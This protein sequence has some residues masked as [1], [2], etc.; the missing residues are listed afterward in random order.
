MAINTDSLS[1]ETA[2]FH[3]GKET[4]S[5]KMNIFISPPVMFA[6]VTT[7]CFIVREITPFPPHT[8][9]FSDRQTDKLKRKEL[10]M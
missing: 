1:I 5:T 7:S 3:P 8:L 9:T 4:D 2:M 10:S 6:G